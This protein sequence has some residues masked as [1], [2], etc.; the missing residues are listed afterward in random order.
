MTKQQFKQMLDK[1]KEEIEKHV[2]IE[3]E[4]AGKNMRNEASL[5]WVLKYAAQ[6]RK[7]Y[8]NAK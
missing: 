8:E 3:S 6:W 4:K 7:N 5:D 2:W 1:E